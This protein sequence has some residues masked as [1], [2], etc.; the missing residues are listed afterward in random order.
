MYVCGNVLTALNTISIKKMLLSL[1]INKI[2]LTNLLNQKF[3][4]CV[5]GETRIGFGHQQVANLSPASW[6][7]SQLRFEVH[8]LIYNY[9]MKLPSS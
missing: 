6:D 8:D 2:V 3:V 1:E 9:L 7:Y 4:D 5:L